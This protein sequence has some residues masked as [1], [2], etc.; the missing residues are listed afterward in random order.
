MKY[1][2]GYGYN[3]RGERILSCIGFKL[4]SQ[5][6]SKASHGVESGISGP[7]YREYFPHGAEVLLL[8][9]FLNWEVIGSEDS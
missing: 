3:S 7:Q 6:K 9:T 1:C 5:P 2:D 4:S 8:T